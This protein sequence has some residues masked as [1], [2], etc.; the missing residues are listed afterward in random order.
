MLTEKEIVEEIG[1]IVKM[2]YDEST[3]QIDNALNDSGFDTDYYGEIRGM[4]R[5]FMSLA[6]Q[7]YEERQYMYQ[8]LIGDRKPND[9]T[10]P[11]V[12]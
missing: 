12:T 10:T 9:P 6:Q 3:R 5:Q 8:A 1:K 7:Q 2:Q 4:I 11:R